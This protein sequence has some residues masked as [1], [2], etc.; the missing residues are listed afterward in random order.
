MGI[1]T[2]RRVREGL[3]ELIR[4]VNDPATA[5]SDLKSVL[6]ECK[7]F[8]AQLAVLQADTAAGVAGR[9]RH[10][11]SGVG[12]LAQAAGLS[13]RDAA[14]QVQ[15]AQSLQS[16]PTVRDAVQSGQI[17][18]AN[19]K[20]LARASA[21]TSAVQVDAD[22]A[23]LEKAADLSPEAFSREAGRWAVK[24]QNDGGEGEYRRQRARRR[25]SFW[26]GDDGMVHLRGDLD[27]V[28]GAKVRKRFVQ[29]AERLRRADLHSPGGDKRSLSQRMADALDTLTSHG[30]IY[31]QAERA[32]T[33]RDNR[34]DS[35]GNAVSGT[36]HASGARGGDT[37]RENA[38]GDRSDSADAGRGG[39]PGEV[40]PGAGARGGEAGGGDP[41]EVDP[42]AGARGGEAGGGDP[43][44]VDPGAGARGGEAGGG[45][46]GE[47]DP[48]AGARG[49]EAGGGDPGEVDPG[50]GSRGGE[51]GGGDPGEVDPGA[52]ARGGE[53]GGGDPGEVDPGAGARGGEAGG[54]DPGEVDPGAGARGGEAGGGDPGEVDPGAGARGGEAGGGDPG[55]VDPGAGARGG[56][57]GGGDPG[58]GEASGVD[59]GGGGRCGC[60]RRPSADITIVQHLSADG[61]EAFAEVA[62]GG[63]I[64]QSVLEEYFCDARI[65]GVVFSSEGVPLWHGHTKRLATKAQMNALRAR[66]GACG[67][68]GADM[69]VCQGHHVEPVSRGGATNI[70]NMMLVC[71][72]CHQKIHHHGWREVPDG[73][74][75]YTIV[76]PERIRY[77][78]PAPPTHPQSTSRAGVMRWR[79]PAR[80]QNTNHA[81]V[82]RH[83]AVT[84]M[85]SSG[86]HRPPPSRLNRDL[87]PGRPSRCSPPPS[88][89]LPDAT[90]KRSGDGELVL[91]LSRRLAV[92]PW[93]PPCAAVGAEPRSRQQRQGPV[94]VSMYGG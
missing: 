85:R 5:T 94:R 73:R 88:R 40:D 39:D 10:G 1:E 34:R 87:E 93:P 16:M 36:N 31:S 27:P 48:G 19:A 68:C 51:A 38:W 24:R 14:G 82:M 3:A 64:P 22:A 44:E 74:G 69:W 41:G 75:L 35:A 56:E 7:T 52:G 8:G 54:G 37:D 53:A 84:R 78:P 60:S 71:W 55:E 13:R 6:A 61:T 92:P 79:A 50:A 17:S 90:R 81:G 83:S 23:L 12:V 43:G 4:F 65:T 18:V 45:D 30:S 80:R 66:Y 21:Q 72:A 59:S 2:A 67:G 86:R 77:G 15:T 47:V 29:E 33:A 32:A 62:G 58:G 76:P 89:R 63:V 25:L 26:D 28:T 91:W 42:G 46:P 20:V 70:E 9:E 49:G 11:D 57:A